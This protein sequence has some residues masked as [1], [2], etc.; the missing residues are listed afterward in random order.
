M[1]RPGASPRLGAHSPE[2]F[3]EIHSADVKAR[4]LTDGGFAKVTT[5]F[6]SAI[7]KVAVTAGQQRGSIFAPIH[8]SDTTAA[9]ARIGELVAPANDPYSGQPELKATPARV[10]PVEFAYRGFALTRHAIALPAGTWFARVAVA[11][12]EGL[13]FATNE[14]PDF[15]QGFA[16]TLTTAENELAEY[17][18]PPRGLVRIAAFR[19]GQLD[20]CIFVGPAKTP[21]QWDAVRLLFEAGV[22]SERDRRILLSGRSGD[23]LAETGPVI[24]ACYSIGLLAIR[25]AIATGEAASV[26]DIGRA[27]RAGTNCGSCV[28]ELR[29]IIEEM[30]EPAG[31]PAGAKP[32][33]VPASA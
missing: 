14:P 32:T 27:L 8:W 17:V 7:L 21:P 13:L 29:A 5:P 18:D 19:S 1:P 15:W 9:H 2:P 20:A 31:S 16:T 10:E 4:K 6:G 28:A 25:K 23:G 22:V 12:G 30:A 26:A 3:I 33:A 11:N 24:C